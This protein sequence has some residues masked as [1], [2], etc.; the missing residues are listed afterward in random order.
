MKYIF[1]KEKMQELHC[2]LPVQVEWFYDGI[3]LTSKV[4]PAKVRENI[5]ELF[6][7]FILHAH[8]YHETNNFFEF[9]N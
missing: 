1:D 7:I 6:R 9:L 8:D 2:K 5:L 4:A 3:N